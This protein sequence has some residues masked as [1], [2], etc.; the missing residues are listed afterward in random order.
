MFSTYLK[1][2]NEKISYV[3]LRYLTIK[4]FEIKSRLAKN[5]IK[6]VS[7]IEFFLFFFIHILKSFLQKL[8]I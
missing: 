1:W 2:R 5:N 3:E 6:N 7:I 4:N 8:K